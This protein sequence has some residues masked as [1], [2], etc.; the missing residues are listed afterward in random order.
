MLAVSVTEPDVAV[1]EPVNGNKIAIAAVNST[2]GPEVEGITPIAI[3]EVG[4]TLQ[5]N[6]TPDI[7]LPYTSNAFA[8]NVSL[9]PAR[10][11]TACGVIATFAIVDGTSSNE[12]LVLV[13]APSEAVIV[14]PLLA[15]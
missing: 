14:T 10:K 8:L 9:S 11:D 5:L 2:S 15:L 6:E 1:I 3:G 12:L 4:L 13:F 7:G